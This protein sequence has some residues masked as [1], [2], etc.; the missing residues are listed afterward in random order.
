[1]DIRPGSMGRAIPGHVVDV[2]DD[3]GNPVQEGTVGEIAVKRPD[4]V[5]FLEYWR[6]PD[7]PA[8]NYR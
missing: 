6:N 4:P 8:K 2:I 1:M 5:M 7:A 3:Q